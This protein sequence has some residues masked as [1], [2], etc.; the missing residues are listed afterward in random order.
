MDREGGDKGSAQSNESPG[1]A[2]VGA[3]PD[4]GVA[5]ADVERRR[6]HHRERVEALVFGKSDVGPRPIR[7]SIPG[8]EESRSEGA[9]RVE[10]SEERRV[11]KE[12]RSRGAA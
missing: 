6:R 9:A 11:G 12:G 10:R 1:L 7:A 8:T 5:D 4:A 2:L 3:P